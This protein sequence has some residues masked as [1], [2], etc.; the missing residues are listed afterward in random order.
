MENEKY[1]AL[2]TIANFYRFFAW[3]TIVLTVFFM[4]VGIVQAFVSQTYIGGGFFPFLGA[5][6]GAV[7]GS[8]VAVFIY[9]AV[10]FIIG[11]LQLAVAEVLYVFMD[12]EVNTRK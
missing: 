2:N 3:F 5:L 4:I 11:T 9:G 7:F 12:I 10:G 1:P 6:L 8:I